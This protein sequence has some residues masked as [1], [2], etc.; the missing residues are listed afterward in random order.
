MQR[1]RRSFYFVS[2]GDNVLHAKSAEAVLCVN[3]PGD[4]AL[5]AKSAEALLFVNM[6]VNTRHAKSTE[7]LLFVN[8]GDDT[9]V[10]INENSS[11]GVCTT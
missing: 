4:N 9:N 8:M 10:P 11:C 3:M 1:V 6:G 2:I 7:A 5:R